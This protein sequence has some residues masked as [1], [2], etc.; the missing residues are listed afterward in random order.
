MK[1]LSKLK[2]MIEI[3]IL[4]PNALKNIQGAVW[5][6]YVLMWRCKGLRHQRVTKHTSV[7]F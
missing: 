6:D 2:L 5:R 4:L 3:Q 7:K 1:E